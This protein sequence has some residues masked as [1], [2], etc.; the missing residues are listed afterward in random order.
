MTISAVSRALLVSLLAGTS[1]PA[2]A[3]EAETGDAPAPV[4]PSPATVEGAR[5]YTP[6]DFAR[7]APKNALDMLRQVPGFVIK[8]AAQERGLG[9]ATG[10]VLINGQR[11]SGKS[12]DVLT[13]LGRIP[14]S[15]VTRIEILDGA[16]LDIP[17]LSG[18]VA[19]IVAKSGGAMSG[20]FAWEPSFRQRNTDPVLTR[21][22]VSVSGKKG[23]FEYTLGLQNN[24]GASGANGRTLIYNPDLSVREFRYDRWTGESENPRVS[25][26]L[27]YDGPGSSVG[28]LNA[29]YQRFY[30]DYL[31]RGERTGSLTVP[32][33]IRISTQFEESY[34][35]E[36]GGDYEVKLGPGRLKFIGLNR[37]DHTPFGQ[38]VRTSFADNSPDSGN[39]F[40]RT[41]DESERIGR[42]EYKWKGGGADWQISGEAAF[43]SL[44]NVSELFILQPD[45]EFDEID[46]DG[47]TA[48]VEEDRYEV[49]AS[50][51]RTL[52]PKLSIQLAAGGEYSNLR[53]AGGGGLSRTF[54]RPKGQFS[55]AWKPNKK[56]DVNL[57]LQRRVGQLS[58]YDF[59][60]TVNLGNESENAGNPDLV[61]SQ[62]WH[63]EVETI[64][65]LGAYGSTTFRVYGQ[66]I[67][68]IIDTIPIGTNGESPGN[69][70]S[71]KVWGAE[72]K[73]TFQFDPMGWKGAKLDAR[74]QMQGSSLRDPLTGETRP[75][76][77]TLIR[78][79]TLSL[80]HD[81][82]DSDWAW[83]GALSHE[84]YN[85][86]Y[87][88]TEVGR[89]W[90]GPVWTS[91]FVE[92]KDVFG[93][94]VR[95]T[96]TNI[97]AARSVWDR[98]VYTGRRTGPVDF[99]E[100]RD[101]LIGPIFSF[102]VRGKF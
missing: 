76:S 64:R 57:R 32:D 24:A 59:L 83:G 46:L 45:G 82:P 72:W 92:N 43:N 79:A 14:A 84:W 1:L 80:R 70:A 81:I 91:L 65:N 54:W 26:R 74:V 7:F 47:G 6:E 88:L 36:I 68:D 12:N 90:E 35:Y 71:A 31:E 98:T 27:T 20:Q 61:P 8:E 10:N 101:R 34:G 86:N 97:T 17:G 40:V 15:N 37:F 58:F 13:E 55:A 48:R 89:Q 100:R 29:S 78:L 85:K 39:R 44:D 56:T 9:Q 22:S 66:L 69:I 102:A 93:L 73:T 19:N 11:I 33:R 23:A 4:A 77:N 49:M 5:T 18:Q 3:Q 25:G 2:F 28:N 38:E 60:A 63:A 67:D 42:L 87:R 30:Y 62:T 41:G 94:T 52:S 16:T 21:G 95:A 75:I 51:G 53:Q 99:Y 50:Y 96:V